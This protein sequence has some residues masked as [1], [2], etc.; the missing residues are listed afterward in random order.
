MKKINHDHNKEKEIQAM[1]NK[2][3]AKKDFYDKEVAEKE[4]NVAYSRIMLLGSAGVGKTC[5]TR[6][7]MKEKYQRDT[8]STII[9]DVK[10][11]RPIDMSPAE[12]Q[13][14]VN[15]TTKSPSDEPHYK[16][17]LK[18]HDRSVQFK[19]HMLSENKKWKQVDENDE[20]DE[21]AY[22]ISAVYDEDSGSEDLRTAVAALLLYKIESP[23]CPSDF[24]DQKIYREEV[25]SFLAK[26]I[27]RAQEIEPV[28][29]QDIKPQPFM[30]IWD[31]G[32]QAVFLEILPAFLSSRTMFFL[33]FNAAKSL[34]EK[35][36]NIRTYSNDP[37]L[38][39]L[40]EWKIGG[41]CREDL[42]E[43]LKCADLHQLADQ[44]KVSDYRPASRRPSVVNVRQPTN[45]QCS[46]FERSQEIEA[47][48][49]SLIFEIAEA[50]VKNT[51]DSDQL[52]DSYINQRHQEIP[53]AS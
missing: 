41:G 5:F 2:I 30:H 11:V 38:H 13:D 6:S 17:Q 8:D 19:S 37:M 25:D 23:F 7:L 51:R 33:L 48:I 34:D 32:G 28:P 43:A 49:N 31:C 46:D 47:K 9:S 15:T 26:A 36:K 39:L 14:D 29:I 44:V 35:W 45:E 52:T 40:Y 1:A 27:K 24:S 18:S 10:S 4:V 12:Q 50:Q 42:I 20:I 21:V 53:E 3:R 22:L 16:L